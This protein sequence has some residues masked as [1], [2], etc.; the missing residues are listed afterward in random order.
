[1][2]G[3]GGAN[4]FMGRV[5]GIRTPLWLVWGLGLRCGFQSICAWSGIHPGCIPLKPHRTHTPRMHRHRT[6]RTPADD[7]H[8]LGTEQADALQTS[9]QLNEA[10]AR[11]MPPGFAAHTSTSTATSTSTPPETD[12][13]QRL[14]A[15]R[16]R[17]VHAATHPTSPNKRELSPLRSTTVPGAPSGVLLASVRSAGEHFRGSP[18]SIEVYDPAEVGR[19]VTERLCPGGIPQGYLEQVRVLGAERDG[20]VEQRALLEAEVVQMK[21][22]T[23]KLFCERQEVLQGEMRMMQAMA[24]AHGQAEADAHSAA[25]TEL[26]TREAL[27]KANTQVEQLRIAALQK[28]ERKKRRHIERTKAELSALRA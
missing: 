28:R 15:L 17:Y 23:A 7:P 12:L 6:V 11:Y 8:H 4:S 5:C 13:V 24:S 27:D 21:A 22:T 25:Q 14:H 19:Y 3:R 18:N 20:L 26:A 1:M 2:H 10:V 16:D 9:I